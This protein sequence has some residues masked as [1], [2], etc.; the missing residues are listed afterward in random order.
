[1]KLSFKQVADI[2]PLAWHGVIT[3]DVPDVQILRGTG[4][5]VWPDRFAEGAWAG[6]FET[7][8]FLDHAFFGSG[9]QLRGDE[10]IFAAPEHLLS[11]LFVFRTPQQVHVSNSLPLLLASTDNTLDPNAL[12]LQVHLAPAKGLSGSP[13]ILPLLGKR[14]IEMHYWCQLAFTAD[15]QMRLDRRSEEAP[16]DDFTSYRAALLEVIKAVLDNAADPARKRSY[17][18]LSTI[19]SGYDS[20]TIT[21]LAAEAGCTEAVTFGAARAKGGVVEPDDG[22]EVMA[23]LDMTAHVV[24]RLGYRASDGMPE[25]ETWGQGSEMLALRDMLGGRVLLVGYYG[26]SVWERDLP[27]LSADVKWVLVA[28]HNLNDLR[29][30]A[31]YIM[32]NVPFL[33]GPHLAQINAISR[34]DEMAPWTL[35]DNYD[36]PICRRIVEE[37][38]VPRAAFG[39]KKLATGVFAP[40]EGMRNTMTQASFADYMQWRDSKNLMP[41]P[42]RRSLHNIRFRLWD[43]N[44]RIHRKVFRITA[45]RFGGRGIKVPMLFSQVTQ[46]NDASH[47]FTWAM[48]RLSEN[49]ARALSD[50]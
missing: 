31:D 10:I 9:G 48:E 46:I 26:D 17:A 41:G 5:D 3:K 24:D 16:F 38:G 22:K 43:L 2:P 14:H 13:L 30:S 34:S 19:S 8:S 35:Y 42:L 21:V 47:A 1:M 15:L 50:A 44:G 6:P 18:P 36:R 45:A 32:F 25:L 20:T 39:Q 33:F 29:L 37:A 40:Q 12:D 4:V 27:G 11:G 49:Y 28:G 23:H 7:S